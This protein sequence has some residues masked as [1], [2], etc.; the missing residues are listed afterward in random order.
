[1]RVFA[2]QYF[3]ERGVEEQGWGGE[4]VWGDAV[5]HSNGS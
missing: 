2:L 5:L 4:G 1:M 3:H